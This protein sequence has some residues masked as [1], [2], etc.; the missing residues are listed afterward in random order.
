MPPRSISPSGKR[1]AATIVLVAVLA[2]CEPNEPAPPAATPRDDIPSQV[3]DGGTV[4]F[5][6]LGEPPTLDPYAETAS[7]LTYFLARP[8]YRSLYEVTPDGDVEADLVETTTPFERGVLVTLE[9]ARWS[10]GSPITA[11]DVA[12]SVARAREPSGFAG[13]TARVVDRRTVRLS[14]DVSGDW[15]R[16]LAVGTFVLP[17]GGKDKWSGPF[18]V[19]SYVPGLQLVL[20]RNVASGGGAHLDR[21]K[22]QFI[23]DLEI[24]LALLES[25]KLDAGAPPSAV[26]LDDRLDE[27]RLRHEETPGWETIALD[28]GGIADRALR[29]TI[30]GSVDRDRIAE[31][32][33]R[34]EGVVL[35][36]PQPRSGTGGG[37]E[38]QFGTASGDEL[39]QLMQ[40][41]LQKD[42]AAGEVSSEL[43]QVDPATLYGPWQFDSPVDVM[44]RREIHPGF[45]APGADDDLTWFPLF[46]VHSFLAWN[47]GVNGLVPN[48]ALD[49]PLWNAEDWWL[50]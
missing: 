25:G 41:V 50:D 27:L 38:I 17:P 39:L 19:A 26:N 8:V 32:I 16:R 44:L 22:I 21:I 23:S 14:G 20:E 46:S 36:V 35:D 34:D 15:T 31:G 43:A 24:M 45:D 47:E 6:V 33:V 37:V 40:R 1:V 7:D 28:L 49:G 13:L 10:D 29:A 9:P 3:P 42:F 11:G 30:V 12:A 5:G 4:T 18:T 48:G 2:A